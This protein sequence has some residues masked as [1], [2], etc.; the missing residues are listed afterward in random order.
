MWSKHAL[1][2]ARERFPHLTLEQ[3]EELMV[4]SKRPGKKMR[5]RIRQGC[6]VAA[7][8][9]MPGRN[10]VGRYYLVHRSGVVFVMGEKDSVIT[11]FQ[12]EENP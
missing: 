3:L 11:L 10:F 8:Q 2:R 5:T 6:P 1:E 7:R 12:I 4:R 9:W